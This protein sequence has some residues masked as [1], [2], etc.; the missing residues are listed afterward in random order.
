MPQRLNITLPQ[1]TIRLIDRSTKK[2]DRSR[3]IDNAVRFFVK[4]HR[5]ADLRAILKEGA[6]KRAKRDLGVTEDW[7]LLEDDPWQRHKE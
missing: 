6:V 5:R 3:F 2:G 4:E 1:E 7:F